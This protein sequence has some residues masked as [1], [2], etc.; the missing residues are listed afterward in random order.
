MPC[1]DSPDFPA[2]L[3][4]FDVDRTLTGEQGAVK[5][6][7]G[8]EEV[9]GVMDTWHSTSGTMVLSSLAQ[10]IE[11]TFCSRCFRGA[12]STSK[13]GGEGSE[14]REVVVQVLGGAE[15]SLSEKWSS[16]PAHGTEAR[17][18]L[19]VGAVE[20]QQ[21]EAARSIVSWFMSKHGITI[22]DDHVHFFSDRRT[23]VLPFNST[24]FNAR[25][26]SCKTRSDGG[27]GL[28]GAVVAEI[29][30]D[31]GVALCPES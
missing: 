9:P 8:N 3:C 12:V 28:C 23:S 5:S 30:E 4:L 19:V 18:P 25:Q 13:V 15:A 17:S 10:G 11:R 2:C 29:V 6:C 20:G 7:P 22:S 16:A 26:V 31:V 14:N 24:S 21:H 27:I 1:L